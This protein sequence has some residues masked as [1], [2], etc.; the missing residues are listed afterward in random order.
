MAGEFVLLF[1]DL[2]FYFPAQT[3]RVVRKL[4]P[5]EAP[6]VPG[7]ML[8]QGPHFSKTNDESRVFASAGGESP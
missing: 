2:L 5:W 4:T 8:I 6:G 7:P 1:H 3:G